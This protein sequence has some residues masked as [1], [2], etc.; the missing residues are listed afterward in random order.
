MTRL[1]RQLAFRPLSEAKAEALVVQNVDGTQIRGAL[2]AATIG[3]ARL[4]IRHLHLVAA[5]TAT[6]V[7]AVATVRPQF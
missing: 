4:V 2:L 6:V 5:A 1:S 7:K 3:D